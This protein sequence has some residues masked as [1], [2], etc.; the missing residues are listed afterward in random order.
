[1]T[2][3]PRIGPHG[4]DDDLTRALRQLYAAPA[5]EAYWR[6]LERRILARLVEEEWWLPLAAWV[7]VGVIAAGVAL[8]VASLALVR[9]HRAEAQFAYQAVIET[10]RTA[11]LQLATESGT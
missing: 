6:T 8:T 11:P 5:D 4:R 2:L 1:M 9:S 3:E 10:P 7:R